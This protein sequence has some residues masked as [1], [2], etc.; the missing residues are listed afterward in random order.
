MNKLFR[1]I[2]A[3]A[4]VS[5]VAQDT[6]PEPP[7]KTKVTNI[8]VD[9]TATYQGK[10][11][12]SLVKDDFVIRDEGQVRPILSFEDSPIALDLI[13]VLDAALEYQP[14][15]G[16]R[17][18]AQDVAAI[19]AGAMKQM[20]PEDRAG[21]ISINYEPRHE[22]RVECEL[23][24]DAKA[25][26]AALE[27]IRFVHPPGGL[28]GAEALF[29]GP[30]L[31]WAAWMLGAKAVSFGYGAQVKPGARKRAVL[32]IVRD[33]RGFSEGWDPDELL[34]QQYWDADLVLHAIMVEGLVLKPPDMSFIIVNR[35][36]VGERIGNI[37][38]IVRA[39]GGE[40]I[41][42]T[43]ENPVERAIPDL[44]VRIQSS[45]TLFYAS[46]AARSGEPRK[47][48]VQLSDEAKK[49]YPGAEIHARE[50]YI[51]Q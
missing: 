2:L 10:A 32:A 29:S 35:R 51:A 5:V 15:K 24:A 45:Y 16:A 3:F 17:K 50:G 12:L 9:A 26:V 39:T 38:H 41:L 47:I 43:R 13:L 8:Q 27:G 18:T 4:T 40:L 20:R 19:M 6:L 46:P 28:R 42:P 25:V 31:R 23:T 44:L 22:P 34:I 21:L 33:Q 14:P 11:L 1:G 7:F 30:G 48:T 37:S 36:F 49:K